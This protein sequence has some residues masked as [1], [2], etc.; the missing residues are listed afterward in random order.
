MPRWQW[1]RVHKRVRRRGRKKIPILW[2]RQGM[3]SQKGQERLWNTR[4]RSLG[5]EG[6]QKWGNGPKGKRAKTET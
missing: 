3:R 2:L 1:W 5:L 6:G 4:F